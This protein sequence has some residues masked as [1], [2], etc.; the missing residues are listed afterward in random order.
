LDGDLSVLDERKVRWGLK[1]DELSDGE[2][3]GFAR[4]RVESPPIS[5]RN[6]LD[7]LSQMGESI[8]AANLNPDFQIDSLKPTKSIGFSF[9]SLDPKEKHKLEER[10]KRD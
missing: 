2:L 4:P 6:P 1:Q 5:P 9:L 3:I 8:K 10:Q 7:Q